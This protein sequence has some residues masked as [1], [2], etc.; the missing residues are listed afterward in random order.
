LDGPWWLLI[1]VSVEAV[2]AINFFIDAQC[3]RRRLVDLI[4]LARSMTVAVET[5]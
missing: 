5:V 2:Y 4:A 3:D 1:G